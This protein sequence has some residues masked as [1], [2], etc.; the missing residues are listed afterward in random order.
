[1][2]WLF[3]SVEVAAP[4][5]PANNGTV[6]LFD[7]TKVFG[8]KNMRMFGV[9]RVQLDFQ[10][11]DQASA[12]SGLI[13]YQSKDGGTTWTKFSFGY[14]GSAS[15]TLPATVPAATADDSTTYDIFVG[16]CKDVKFT[17]TA[18]A[19]APTTGWPPVIGYR[20][21]DVKTGA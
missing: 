1:M 2:G 19:T 8:P 15:G 20:Q 11:L 4:A 7:S 21:G 17:F 5:A 3:E 6:T 10:G 16:A 12:A 13:G 9:G 18:G 14:T